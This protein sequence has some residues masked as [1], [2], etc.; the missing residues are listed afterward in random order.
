MTLQFSSLR[1]LFVVFLLFVAAT[2]A[3]AQNGPG[4]K[5]DITFT[6]DERGDAQV[7]VAMTMTAPQWQ[8]WQQIYGG[9]RISVFKREM[10]RSLAPYFVENFGYEQDDINRSVRITL[11]AKG[12]TEYLGNGAW[13]GELD[14][15]DPSVTSVSQNA[16]LLTTSTMEGGLL[17]QQNQR[18]MLPEDA[19]SIEHDEDAFGNAIFRYQRPATEQAGMPWL[20]LLGILAAG[21]GGL[22]GG[23]VW[24]G[25]RRSTPTARPGAETASFPLQ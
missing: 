16:F 7:E 11:A 10:E 22:W 20:L 17:V 24:W 19:H 9:G 4:L 6:V 1:L 8:N 13:R 15:K 18:I 3:M 2:G 25:Q 23:V 5:Q 12:V 14:M 21:S